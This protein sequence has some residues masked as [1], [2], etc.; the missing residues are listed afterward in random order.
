MFF[1]S[2]VV[3][4]GKALHS[5]LNPFDL[6]ESLWWHT[7]FFRRQVAVAALCG[8]VSY[9]GMERGSI[10]SAT[11]I[12]WLV[13]AVVFTVITLAICFVW[14]AKALARIPKPILKYLPLAFP[15][16]M[17]YFSIW[18]FQMA[19]SST[20]RTTLFSQLALWAAVATVLGIPAIT[21]LYSRSPR[22]PQHAS[23]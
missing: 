16:G 12:V 4:K 14:I 15:A 10:Q 7:R 2:L 17:L 9:L 22:H 21:W 3:E 13:I 8:I 11:A 5:K 6:S 1:Q 19:F 20:E 18:C 23:D